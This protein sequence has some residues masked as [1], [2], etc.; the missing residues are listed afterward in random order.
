MMENKLD[1]KKLQQQDKIVRIISKTVIYTFL[2]IMAI[3]VIIPFYWMII[4]G[5]KNET[6]VTLFPPTLYPNEVHLEN[7]INVLLPK[8]KDSNNPDILVHNSFQFVTFF[9]NTMLVAVISMVGTL[10]TTILAAYAFA[11]MEF[12]GKDAIFAL[13]LATMMI[14]GEMMVITNYLTVADFGWLN[15]YSGVVTSMTVPFFV[16][17]FYIFLLRQNFMQIPHELYLAAKVDGK[18][19]FLYLMKVM[20]PLAMPTI[21]TI[22]ILKIMG[23]WNSYAWPNLVANKEEWR[24]ITNGLRGA[25]TDSGTGRTAENLQM[26]ATFIVTL[27]LLI[28]FLC[29]RK[30]IMSGVSRSGI[31]G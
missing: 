26:A 11:K 3:I 24:L 16:S 7:F 28:M 1:V 8:V 17:V 19:D 29:F 6:E 10:V 21:T 23:A 13:L 12:K 20:I 22:I 31:K 15:S 27:P 14:P 5:M 25:F 2:V 4:T 18:S 9:K 30:Y